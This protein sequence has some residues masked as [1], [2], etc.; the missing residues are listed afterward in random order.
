MRVYLVTGIAVL[1]LL[2][3]GA[4]AMSLNPN[5]SIS[6]PYSILY[7]D[8]STKVSP[9]IGYYTWAGRDRMWQPPAGNDSDGL[10]LNPDDCN[11]G[12]ALSNG[13]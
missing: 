4:T 13:A 12:C 9:G 11:R 2:I 10:S 7:S 3:E 6:S 5:V 8:K 1:M